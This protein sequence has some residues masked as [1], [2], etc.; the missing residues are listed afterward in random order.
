MRRR[1]FALHATFPRWPLLAP[2]TTGQRQYRRARRQREPEDS[3]EL[4]RKIHAGPGAKRAAR[5]EPVFTVADPGSSY[6]CVA[7]ASRFALSPGYQR[8]AAPG[9]ARSAE[10]GL[11][12]RRRLLEDGDR[13]ILDRQVTAGNEVLEQAADHVA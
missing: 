5:D 4:V 2:C 13:A 6:Y 12:T 1:R 8:C 3:R 10:P 7:R 9:I 11:P